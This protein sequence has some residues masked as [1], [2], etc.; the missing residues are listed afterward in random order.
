MTILAQTI[1]IFLFYSIVGLLTT[2]VMTLHL[3]IFTYSPG[4]IDRSLPRFSFSVNTTATTHGQQPRKKMNGTSLSVDSTHD[5]PLHTQ[6][7]NVPRSA[8][9]VGARL[10]WV[11]PWLR[12]KTTTATDYTSGDARRERLAMATT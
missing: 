5:I 10:P 11:D 12:L 7:S 4:S 6:H 3:G 9:S 2:S 8:P 1:N